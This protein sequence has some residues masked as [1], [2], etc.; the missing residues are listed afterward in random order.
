MDL[1]ECFR[2]TNGDAQ[3]SCQIGRLPRVPLKNLRGRGFASSSAPRINRT[4]DADDAPGRGAGC[5][6]SL[7]SL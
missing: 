4:C 6:F 2:Q 1:I 5:A 7:V 3:E